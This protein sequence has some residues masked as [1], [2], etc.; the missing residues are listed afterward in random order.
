MAVWTHKLSN[1]AAR[2]AIRWEVKF[3]HGLKTVTN[4]TVAY[5][6]ALRYLLNNSDSSNRKMRR[7]EAIDAAMKSVV[8][9]KDKQT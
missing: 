4:L 9:S 5:C 7:K 8:K 3:T 1:D 2:K 6:M